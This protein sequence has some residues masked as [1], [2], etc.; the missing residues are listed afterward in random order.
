MSFVPLRK[1]EPSRTSTVSPPT[2]ITRLMY[3]SPPDATQFLGRVEDDDVA[4]L[5]RVEVGRQLVDEDVLVGLERVLHRHLLDPVR[6]GDERLDDPEDDEGQDE[7]FGDLEEAPDRGLPG[8]VVG[9]RE[10]T[11][12]AV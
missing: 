5:V 1:T 12:P 8:H 4:A 3:G 6:L 7:G 2:P 9:V 10:V 11:S